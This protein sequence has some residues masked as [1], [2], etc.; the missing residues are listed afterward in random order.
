MQKMESSYFY[1]SLPQRKALQCA[2]DRQCLCFCQ[3]GQHVECPGKEIKPSLAG[4]N[5]AQVLVKSKQSITKA[6]PSKC[7]LSWKQVQK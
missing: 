7:Q 3:T 4:P 5:N 2:A 6:A 1:L